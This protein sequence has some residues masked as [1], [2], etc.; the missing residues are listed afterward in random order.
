MGQTVQEMPSAVTFGISDL[1]YLVQGSVDKKTTLATILGKLPV[2]PVNFSGNISLFSDTIQTLSGEG[3]V[4]ST[5]VASFV[6][7]SAAPN[8]LTIQNGARVGQLKIIFFTG[9]GST[10]TLAGSNLSV[11]SI[12]FSVAGTT[13]LLV[14]ADNKW[15]P[16]GGTAV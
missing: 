3:V 7:N 8:A 5:E 13:A 10:S 15:W 11:A 2:T 9:G 16:I 14:W 6:S 12:P 1:L 4:T